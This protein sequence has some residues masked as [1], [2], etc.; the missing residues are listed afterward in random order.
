MRVASNRLWPALAVPGAMLPVLAAAFLLD[1]LTMFVVVAYGSAYLLDTLA[2]PPAYPGYA[3][4]LY[5]LVKLAGALGGGWALQRAGATA[6]AMVAGA[7]LLAGPVVMLIGASVTGFLVGVGV[8][9]AGVAVAWLVVYLAAG[10]TTTGDGRGLAA[11]Y[12]G[13][14]SAVASATGIGLAAMFSL[15]ESWRAAFGLGVALA[16]IGAL[17]LL[18]AAGAAQEALRAHPRQPRLPAARPSMSVPVVVLV[19]AHFVLL[20]TVL[21]AYGPFALRTLDLSLTIALLAAAPAA[22]A[23]AAMMVAAGRGS[24]H[25][26][27]LRRASPLYAFAAIGAMAALFAHGPLGFGL[28]AAPLAIGMAGTLPLINAGLM[29]SSQSVRRPGEALGV[30]FF[31][32]GLGSVVGPALIAAVVTLGGVRPSLVAV[33]GCA[34]ALG[35]LAGAGARRNWL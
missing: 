18:R 26:G 10:A 7:L 11:A 17:A 19:F 25:G 8:V 1:A 24:Q 14:T 30:L 13:L 33:S 27:R 12:L 34:L 35:A 20:S 31:A 16:A 23:G 5:G 22:L 3:L 15:A 32:E 2:A 29:D 21:A 6:T 4:A 9:S 28:A